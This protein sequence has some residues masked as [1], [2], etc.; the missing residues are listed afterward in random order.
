MNQIVIRWLQEDC[1]KILDEINKQR[2]NNSRYFYMIPIHR[3]VSETFKDIYKMAST[4]DRQY[5]YKEFHN[6]FNKELIKNFNKI[7]WVVNIKD[8]QYEIE[9]D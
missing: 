7:G 2:S 6:T 1:K 8:E 3:I 5:T 9:G 4:T